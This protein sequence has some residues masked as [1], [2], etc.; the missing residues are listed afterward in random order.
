MQRRAQFAFEPDLVE[1]ARSSSARSLHAAGA[2]F[3]GQRRQRRAIASQLAHQQGAHDRIGRSETFGKLVAIDRRQHAIGQRARRRGARRDCRSPPFRRA[4]CRGPARRGWLLTMLDC[5]DL[6]RPDSIRNAVVGA[7]SSAK[8]ISPAL[9]VSLRCRAMP[10]LL[11]AIC[12]R[13]SSH[14]YADS[15][16]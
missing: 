16:A 1:G 12:Q 14:R 3:A 6:D 15:M 8:M 4:A 11:H 13:G 10:L 2:D 7:S 9:D 5:A